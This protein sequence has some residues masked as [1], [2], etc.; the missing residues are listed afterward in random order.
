MLEHPHALNDLVI[1]LLLDDTNPRRSQDGAD[2]LQSMA[3]LALENLALSDAGKAP[4]R[5]HS[6]VMGALHALKADAMSD[7]ARRSAS[8][9][10][11]DANDGA[12][13]IG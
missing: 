9:A 10:L 2:A 7:A 1:A 13:D 8:V 11:F 5:A 4:L 3:A 6:G 12:S